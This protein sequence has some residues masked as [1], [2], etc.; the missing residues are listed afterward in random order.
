MNIISPFQL[1]QSDKNDFLNK[2]CSICLCTLFYPENQEN[3]KF[4]SCSRL[5]CNHIFHND[6]IQKTMNHNH[7]NCP[8]CRTPI[9]KLQNLDQSL[10][11]TI[12]NDAFDNGNVD[13]SLKK[14]FEN[15]G[16]YIDNYPYHKIVFERWRNE[17]LHID[18]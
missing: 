4:V 6:C 15:T 13:P 17:R 18:K 11:L 3:D 7:L 12:R 14:I 2:V 9:V 5:N 16:L 8:E 1:Y 10:E